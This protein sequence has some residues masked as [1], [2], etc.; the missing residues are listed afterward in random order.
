[1]SRHAGL[2]FFLLNKEQTNSVRQIL[3]Q[4]N[5]L[6]ASRV[7]NKQEAVSVESNSHTHMD[8]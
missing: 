1:M 2:V 4:L 6:I 8:L 7:N 5:F 3:N